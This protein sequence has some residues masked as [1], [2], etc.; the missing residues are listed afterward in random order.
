MPDTHDEFWTLS[1]EQALLTL[2]TAAGGLSSKEAEARLVRFGPNS[3]RRQRR[4]SDLGLLL[5]Q[6]RSPIILILLFAAALSLYLGE[7]ADASIIL[8]IVALSGLLGFWQERGAGRAVAKLLE[9]VEIKTRALR[10]GA[11]REIPTAQVVPGDVVELTAGVTIPADGLVLHSRG[12]FVD[13]STLTG[14]TYPA[15]KDP[16]MLPEDTPLARRTNA[17]FMGTHV[18]SGSGSLLVVR[19]GKATEFGRISERLGAREEETGFERGVRR[20]GY[21]LMEITLILVIAIFAVNV[22]LH[23]PVLDSFLFSLA[24]AV[25]LTPQLLPAIISINLAH[26][27]RRMADAKVIVKKL[28][29]IEDFGSMDVLRSASTAPIAPTCC[30]G[31]PSTRVSRPASPTRSTRPSEPCRPATSAAGRS[32]TRSRTTSSESG[33][34]CWPRRT[35]P[36]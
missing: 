33:S 4:R 1:A 15:E 7:R 10:D 5:G 30:D 8:A 23:R 28:A 14:E 13:E 29:S 3:I 35:A 27:A 11:V 18:L 26:G 17:L 21:L 20:F 25:G 2:D 6:F 16:G 9:V 31:P 32:S 12:L 22:Y 34:P 36:G 24:L 19:T